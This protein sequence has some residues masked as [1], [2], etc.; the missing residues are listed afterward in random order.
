MPS[1]GKRR[2]STGSSVA[3][4]D[5][6]TPVASRTGTKGSMSVGGA[7]GKKRKTLPEHAPSSPEVTAPSKEQLPRKKKR[8]S[9]GVAA[10]SA[11]PTNTTKKVKK[12]QK[13][14]KRA[15]E[16]DTDEVLLDL[17]AYKALAVPIPGT[18][19]T[20]YLY[21]REHNSASHRGGSDDAYNSD[22]DD[23]EDEARVRCTLFVTNLPYDCIDEDMEQVFES[24][25]DV[26]EVSFGSLK[27]HRGT[28][29]RALCYSFT[30]TTAAAEEAARYG[31]GADLGGMTVDV[32]NQD[33]H[34]P[35]P[36]LEDGDSTDM[37][38]SGGFARV[39]FANADAVSK[40][41]S[42]QHWRKNPPTMNP[43]NVQKLRGMNKWLDTYHKRR[44]DSEILEGAV[45]NY[46]EQYDIFKDM[47]KR[48]NEAKSGQ[49]DADG[50][51]LVTRRSYGKNTDGTVS[52]GVASKT[53]SAAEVRKKTKE[54][55][56]VNFYRFQQHEK[57]REQIA[58]L[59]QKFEEDKARIAR[60]KEKRKFRPF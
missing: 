29:E 4:T 14:V 31:I 23:D 54:K 46:M 41:L 44:P 8:P 40:A 15:E 57:Q 1:N 9:P 43:E 22:S 45:N 32:S 21:L 12:S 19:A 36:D 10:V 11:T 35:T 26:I 28:R 20:R 59:R 25:G 3:P 55:A 49:V 53:L 39:S 60:M 13:T 2:K 5:V 6:T 38:L 30:T 34:Q 18:P 7:R 16:E 42:P 27:P 17:G 51:T 50:F 47:E 58:T 56:L 52:V 48:E 24:C 33:A 37:L